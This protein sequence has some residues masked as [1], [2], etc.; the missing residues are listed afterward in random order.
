MP[1]LLIKCLVCVTLNR[2]QKG[3][4]TKCINWFIDGT[5][6]SSDIYCT[7]NDTPSKSISTEYITKELSSLQL[8][9]YWWLY[10]CHGLSIESHQVFWLSHGI[11]ESYAILISFGNIRLFTKSFTPLIVS[12]SI[13][14]C[15]VF[16]YY[17]PQRFRHFVIYQYPA[18]FK[19]H[20]LEI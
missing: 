4:F 9:W 8:A 6:Y 16:I 18:T 15:F 14:I 7:F 19:Y 3:K 1:C 5:L 10:P 11:F 20:F 13:T 12:R 17:S 2:R